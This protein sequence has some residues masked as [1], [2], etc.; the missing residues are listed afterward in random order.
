MGDVLFLLR[1]RST[2]PGPM[3]KGWLVSRG[4][5][6]GAANSQGKRDR[7]AIPRGHWELFS[8]SLASGGRVV[9]LQAKEKEQTSQAVKEVGTAITRDQGSGEQAC[10]R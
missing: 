4:Q 1:E 2:V 5:Q 8:L 6:E 7:E 3:R 9:L 10:P